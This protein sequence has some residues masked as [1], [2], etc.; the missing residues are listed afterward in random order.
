MAA[1]TRKIE[2]PGRPD[3]RDETRYGGAVPCGNTIY[4][5]TWDNDGKNVWECTNCMNQTPRRSKNFDRKYTELSP[6]QQR[7]I[8]HIR[9]RGLNSHGEAEY[10]WA[11][12]KVEMLS[13]GSVMVSGEIA[14]VDGKGFS[15]FMH[16]IIGRKG[17][18]K[19]EVSG[20]ATRRKMNNRR[21]LWMVYP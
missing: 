5:A 17:S 14:R 4:E 1:R 16:A 11:E 19:G 2:C 20:F 10:H 3:M 12:W 9:K 8:E 18:V 13:G 21:D 6:T 15:T 7:T